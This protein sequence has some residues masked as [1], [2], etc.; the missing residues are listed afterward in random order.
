MY[1]YM[2]KRRMEFLNLRNKFFSRLL[3]KILIAY[4]HLTSRSR[5]GW[6]QGL[7]FLHYRYSAPIFELERKYNLLT[8]H[9]PIYIFFSLCFIYEYSYEVITLS[10]THVEFN[11]V[12]TTS[13]C[14]LTSPVLV[15]V[16]EI[17]N[18]RAADLAQSGLETA[19]VW[20]VGRTS[21]TDET[22]AG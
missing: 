1:L 18:K 11:C 22:K 19:T 3:I 20:I 2:D 13:W 21:T 10:K 5:V 7:I 6:E 12:E 8:N 14:W 17:Y 15:V 4:T 16:G 9:A